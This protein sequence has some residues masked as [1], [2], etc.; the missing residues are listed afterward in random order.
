MSFIPFLAKIV[1][2]IEKNAENVK[3]IVGEAQKALPVSAPQNKAFLAF[4]IAVLLIAIPFFIVLFSNE[5]K[6]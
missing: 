5:G 4:F 2:E 6:E 3:V 1:I